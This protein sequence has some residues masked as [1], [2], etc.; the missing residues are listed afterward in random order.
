MIAMCDKRRVY[1]LRELLESSCMLFLWCIT[2][3]REDGYARAEAHLAIC[4]VVTEFIRGKDA[5]DDKYHWRS[6]LMIHEYSQ[7]L[8]GDLDKIIG[9]PIDVA[10]TGCHYDLYL[11]RFIDEWVKMLPEFEKLLRPK[12]ALVK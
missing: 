11:N 8:T 7:K 12:I 9:F 2:P 3:G 4:K 10:V 1:D 6:V 5:S